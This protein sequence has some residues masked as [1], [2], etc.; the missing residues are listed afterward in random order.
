M[1]GWTGADVKNL[2]NKGVNISGMKEYKA[3]EPAGK[4]HIESVLIRLGI[5]FEK[6]KKFDK[7][8]RFRSDYYVPELNLLIEYEGIYSEIS[9]HTFYEGYSKDVEK[10][11]LVQVNGYR[12]LRYT[13]DNFVMFEE[14]L[15]KIFNL[16]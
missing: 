12:L 7:K 6:E 13:S 15:K 1:K 16:K 14:D 3:P 2:Q 9:R 8:R 4:I 5:E 10:Y 11:N